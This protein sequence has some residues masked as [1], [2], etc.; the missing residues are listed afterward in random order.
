MSQRNSN[1]KIGVTQTDNREIGVP[2]E[3][4]RMI[5]RAYFFAYL[6]QVLKRGTNWSAFSR[7]ILRRSPA[8][9][10]NLFIAVAIFSIVQ[11]GMSDPNKICSLG[12]TLNTANM[13]VGLTATLAVA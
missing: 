12:I 8:E 1:H 3:N 13:A 2:G 7:W 11:N 9:M 6:L 5:L 4:P 10:S